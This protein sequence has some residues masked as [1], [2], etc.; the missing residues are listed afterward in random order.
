MNFSTIGDGAATRLF[1]VAFNYLNA[2]NYLNFQIRVTS[3][4][5]VTIYFFKMIGGVQTLVSSAASP[6]AIPGSTASVTGDLVITRD[7]LDLTATF[8]ATTLTGTILQADADAVA[9]ST[10]AALGGGL[11]NLVGMTISAVQLEVEPTGET[12]QTI[13]FY[14]GSMPGQSLSYQGDRLDDM[15]PVTPDILLIS[16]V[17]N[18]TTTSGATYYGIVA[19]FCD[20]LLSRCPD[21]AIILS[22]QNP[23]KPPAPNFA[24]HAERNRHLRK[25]AQDR[26]YGYIAAFETFLGTTNWQSLVDADGFHTTSAGSLKWRD[27][28]A[29]AV[30]EFVAVTP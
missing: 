26:G 11:G 12:V 8:G 10:E 15:L 2:S 6:A 23:E 5:A 18:Y 3:A 17:H 4:G 30:D 21:A 22:S 27:A 16:S 14:N 13:R 28:A 24:Y 7:G 20:S 19:G 1:T 25:L 29:A 9:A